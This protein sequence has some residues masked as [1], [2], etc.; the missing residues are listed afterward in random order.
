MKTLTKIKSTIPS[1][2]VA[3]AFGFLVLSPMAQA[4]G[5][6]TEG[7]IPGANTG[8][9]I[10]VLTSLT[11]GT[12]N[13]GTGYQAL[14]HLTAGNQNT[15]AGLRAL[16]SDTNGGFNTATGVY[17][18]FSNTTGNYNTATGFDAL[19]RQH[20]RLPEHGQR[21]VRS[22]KQHH[23]RPEHGHWCFSAL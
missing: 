20:Y 6:D 19:L 17:S 14:N 21:S 16:F 7:A 11:G 4:V 12:W 23:W 9:G 15:A 5:P 22:Q 1:L 8:E 13:T 10:G 2:L 3:S 18:L